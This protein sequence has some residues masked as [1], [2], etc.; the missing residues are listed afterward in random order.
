MTPWC[1]QTESRFLLSPWQ[2]VSPRPSQHQPL[3][4]HLHSQLTAHSPFR[5]CAHVVKLNAS[6]PVSCLSSKEELMPFSK[7]PSLTP[8]PK[9]TTFHAPCHVP[10]YSMLPAHIVFV[11][12]IS[13]NIHKTPQMVATAPS[14]GQ[15]TRAHSH[16][17]HTRAV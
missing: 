9:S 8:L 2:S 3:G 14:P 15:G 17:G 11:N 16:T 10:L 1:C 5:A 7:Q 6:S 12:C 13:W 4:T